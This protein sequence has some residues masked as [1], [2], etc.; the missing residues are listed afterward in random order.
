MGRRRT[1][2]AI[3]M[4]VAGLTFASCGGTPN[5]IESV[6]DIRALPDQAVDVDP[7][8][9]TAEQQ[10]VVADGIVTKE[11]LVSLLDDT[12]ECT[13]ARGVEVTYSLLDNNVITWQVAANDLDDLTIETAIS[14]CEEVNFQDASQVFFESLS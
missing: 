12:E 6:E 2:A 14:V 10:A 13:A 4:G 11:E 5:S 3:A 8:A 9:A 7:R 1:L